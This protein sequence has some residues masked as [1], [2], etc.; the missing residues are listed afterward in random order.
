MLF[1]L[2]MNKKELYKKN[3]NKKGVFALGAS[4]C[5]ILLSSA[6]REQNEDFE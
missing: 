4:K 5:G 3:K 2:E 6:F 1:T